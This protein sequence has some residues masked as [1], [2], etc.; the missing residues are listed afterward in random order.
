MLIIGGLAG[1]FLL[2]A[3]WYKYD[4]YAELPAA[5][6]LLS[7]GLLFVAGVSLPLNRMG[8][9]GD[10]VRF[11]ATL[12]TIEAARNDQQTWESAALQ[13]EVVSANRWLA[14]AQYWNHTIFDI[15]ILDA[16]DELTPIR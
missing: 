12:A 16:V 4:I 1:V 10:L 13:Q 2:S 7:G 14:N 15:W 6:W 11:E 9:H 8:V 5:L 3:L